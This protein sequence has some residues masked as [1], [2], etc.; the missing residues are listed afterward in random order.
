MILTGLE[1]R[2]LWLLQNFNRSLKQFVFVIFAIYCYNIVIFINLTCIKL[3][4]RK[5]K[6]YLWEVESKE[7]W[8]GSF[9]GHASTF[10]KRT[11]LPCYKLIKKALYHPKTYKFDRK[12]ANLSQNPSNL[13]SFMSSTGTGADS[14]ISD[15]LLK[16][17]KCSLDGM[18]RTK[19]QLKPNF[20]QFITWTQGPFP[21]AETFSQDLNG[22][23]V[24]NFAKI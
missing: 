2:I 17:F 18:R 6:Q 22:S 23:R 15:H 20:N 9:C 19:V 7:P 12:W 21:L 1:I 13:L 10:P 4:C 3:T 16:V 14:F 24:K 11:F 5:L 8:W